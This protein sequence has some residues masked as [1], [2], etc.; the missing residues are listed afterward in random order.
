MHIRLVY[1]YLLNVPLF[2][3]NKSN[4]SFREIARFIARNPF[5]A[6]MD[7]DIYAVQISP[8]LPAGPILVV[9]ACVL[10]LFI[11]N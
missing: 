3:Q 10:I 8:L 9:Q 7:S 5:A 4:V 2:Q 1:V 11:L 6:T